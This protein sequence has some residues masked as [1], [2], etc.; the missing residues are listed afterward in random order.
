MPESYKQLP[1][2]KY[3]YRGVELNDSQYKQYTKGVGI[4]YSGYGAVA[5]TTSLEGLHDFLNDRD[6]KFAV[7]RFKLSEFADKIILNVPLWYKLVG[8]GVQVLSVTGKGYNHVFKTGHMLKRLV[9]REQE[10]LLQDTPKLLTFD[11]QNSI[12]DKELEFIFRSKK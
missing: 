7:N 8:E 10:I 5:Y 1:K 2:S 4:R 12:S 9:D 11:I 6:S 3:I